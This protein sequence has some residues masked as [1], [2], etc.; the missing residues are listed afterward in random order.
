MTIGNSPFSERVRIT[1]EAR[2]LSQADLADKTGLQPA[3]IA[4]FE[5]GRRSPSMKNLR[6]L[7]LALGVSADYLIGIDKRL[8]TSGVV[9]ARLAKYVSQLS[10]ANLDLLEGIC[11][12]MLKR[13]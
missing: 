6:V 7:S 3:A 10:D 11:K 4:H 9:P 8:D 12:E 2:G 13:Q 1:R 5:A